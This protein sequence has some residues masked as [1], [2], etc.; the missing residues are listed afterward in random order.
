MRKANS[1]TIIVLAIMVLALVGSVAIAL[2][3]NGANYMGTGNQTR[4]H[5][6]DEWAAQQ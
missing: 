2:A 3:N 5:L 1:P 4:Q 6:L